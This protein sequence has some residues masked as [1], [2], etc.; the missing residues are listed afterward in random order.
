MKTWNVTILLEFASY[1]RNMGYL[2]PAPPSS[3]S[4]MFSWVLFAGAARHCSPWVCERKAL[5]FGDRYAWTNSETGQYW[6]SNLDGEDLPHLFHL[7]CISL[8]LM[9]KL[10]AKTLQGWKF[11]LGGGCKLHLENWDVQLP[12]GSSILN[13]QKG[14]LVLWLT[15]WPMF[16]LGFHI[17]ASKFRTHPLSWETYISLHKHNFY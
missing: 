14:G 2:I 1:I 5:F 11:V 15:G 3:P 7:L 16:L 12:R 8:S 9:K 10:M 13:F 17:I 6:E 4:E